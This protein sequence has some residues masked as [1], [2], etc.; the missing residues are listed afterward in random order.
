[1]S[2]TETRSYL[3]RAAEEDRRAADASSVEAKVRHQH[4]ADA[5]RQR[6]AFWRSSDGYGANFSAMAPDVIGQATG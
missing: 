4:C 3:A 1:M 2:N 6:A 5:Y